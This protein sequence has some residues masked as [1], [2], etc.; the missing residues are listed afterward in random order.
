MTIWCHTCRRSFPAGEKE[1]IYDNG[2]NMAVFKCPMCGINYL[3]ID[4]DKT[5]V[6]RLLKLTLTKS[7]IINTEK[8]APSKIVAPAVQRLIITPAE[9]A[10]L[11]RKER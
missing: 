10:A 6:P 5:T 9:V 1:I 2:S 7:Y 4:D 3:A 11:M 8:E